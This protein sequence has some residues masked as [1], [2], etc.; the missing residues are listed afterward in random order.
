MAK[1]INI[2]ENKKEKGQPN[3]YP[4]LDGTGKIPVGEIPSSV[5]DA[6]TYKGA[7]SAAGGTFPGGS[8][9]NGDTYR[10]SVAGTLP[11]PLTAEVGDSLI[12]DG[13][14]I[15][16]DLFQAN[17]TIG[18][19]I[20][21]VQQNG[22][23]LNALEI[24]ETDGAKKFISVAKNSAYNK[25][26]GAATGNVPEIAAGGIGNTH[27][28]ESNGSGQLISAAKNAGYNNA[29]GFD[30]GEVLQGSSLVERSGFDDLTESTLVWTDSGPD[31][32]IAINPTVT[33]FTIYVQGKQFVKTAETKQIADTEGLH[34]IYYDS[35]GILQETITFTE[36]L[37]LNNA[38]V[39]I[40]YWDATNKVAIYNGDERHGWRMAGKTHLHFHQGWGSRWIS[41]LGL[42]DLLVDQNGSL[43]THA[44]LG[45]AAGELHD[46][47]LEFTP[48]A[49]AGPAQIP[50]YY[51]EG[52]TPVWREETADNFPFVRSGAVPQYNLDT[53]GTWSQAGI[54][55]NNFFLTH[56]A[57][58]ND[59][60]R[61]FIY[62]QG[63]AE[64]GT[65]NDAR[66]GAESEIGELLL[67]GL[68]F[69]EFV[70]VG[71][72]IFEYKT[73]YGNSVD[74]RTRS[75]LDGGDYVDWRGSGFTNAIGSSPTS[76]TKV[77]QRT[78]YPRAGDDGGVGGVTLNGVASQV[79]ADD[80]SSGTPGAFLSGVFYRTRAFDQ[81]SPMFI[82]WAFELGEDY[83]EGEDINIL[84]TWM[85]NATTNSVRWQCG[86]ARAGDGDTL[87]L[88]ATDQWGAPQE[89]AAPGVAIQKV[90]TPFTF[91]GVGYKRG[92]T[93]VVNVFRD[94]GNHSG[95]PT[96]ADANL[97]TLKS[98]F[99]V[100]VNG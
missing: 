79:E 52:A 15:Q 63:I 11:G 77:D 68:P 49:D 78:Y 36:A 57:A 16:W 70:F 100:F 18:D 89:I 5:T 45:Y 54:T 84:I 42:T 50:G 43:D 21:Q 59:P 37:I 38:F 23:N 60:S 69:A 28:V 64:Y 80:G 92:D 56:I 48:S 67:V 97:L 73:A 25:T 39:T 76:P 41:G 20:S 27:T 30:A 14:A 40:V 1:I 3:G 31:R 44:Q 62:I 72:V 83:I 19:L 95:T 86:I 22:A 17:L 24:I 26:F 65:V 58:T 4:T 93:V 10:I 13:T 61:P 32:T 51:L 90:V 87:L 8:P 46:E 74:V 47:D 91:S 98:E 75:T 66:A 7:W 71:T 29:Y 88:A 55:N 2:P 12:Y 99:P 35:A 82:D 96:A 53:V 34:F 33:N 85:I 9:A 6:M 81:S 94:P